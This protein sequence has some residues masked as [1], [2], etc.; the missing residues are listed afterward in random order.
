VIRSTLAFAICWQNRLANL[1]AL[2][3]DK[4]AVDQGLDFEV[5]VRGVAHESVI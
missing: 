3:R 4:A 5:D 2:L 1:D